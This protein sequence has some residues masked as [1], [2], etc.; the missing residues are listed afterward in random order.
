MIMLADGG[1]RGCFLRSLLLIA[2]A[3]SAGLG[4]VTAVADQ[5]VTLTFSGMYELDQVLDFYNGGASAHGGD[6]TPLGIT[7]SPSAIV[8]SDVSSGGHYITANEPSGPVVM[9][10]N[11]KRSDGTLAIMN[12][13]AGF[14]NAFSLYYSSPYT[15]GSITIHD[16]ANATGNVL[17]TLSLLQTGSDPNSFDPITG[18]HNDFSVWNPVGVQFAG[19]ARSVNFKGAT[20]VSSNVHGAAFDNITLGASTPQL[21]SA[22]NTPAIV[23]TPPAGATTHDSTHTALSN[24]GSIRVFQSQQTDLTGNT[25][26][27]GGQDVYSAGA[28]GKPVL[29]SLDSAGHKL[30]GMA[31]LPAVSSNGNVVA[32]LFTPSAAK[33]AKDVAAGQMWAGA[34]GQPKHQVDKGMGSMPPN[35][36]AS[37]GPSLSS[38]NGTNQLVFC[39]SASNLVPSDGNG[40][41]DIFLIDPLNPAIAAQRVSLDSTG[42]QLPGD[43]C[44]PKLSGD[45]TQV[46]FS[47]SA[48][49]L[50]NTAARQIVRKN[51]TGG[52]KVLVTGQML[53]ITTAPTTGQPANADNSEPTTNQDGSV[54]AFTSQASN[55]DSL[56]TPVGGREV[57]V[58]L[59]P[60]GSSP[61]LIKRL[62]SGDG[63][64]PNGASQHPQI[65]GDGTTVVMQTS[66]T[67]FFQTKSLQAKA[68]G[69]TVTQQCG[70]VAITTNMFNPSALGSNLCS[71]G[72][73]A[74]SNQNPTISGD[75]KKIAVDSD[76]PQPGTSSIN[77][78]PYVQK[79]VSDSSTV[80]GLSG[81]YS[82]QWFD[83]NQSGQ[84]LVIDELNGGF[85]E[86]IWFV[87]TGGQPTWV[88]GAGKLQTGSGAA[89]G[90]VVVQMDQV[91]IYK[92]VSFPLGTAKATPNLWGSITLTFTD[93]NTGTMY[94]TSSYPGFNSGTMQIQHFLPVSLPAADAAGTKIKS[95]HSG[96][97]KEPNKSGHGF[98]FAVLATTPP[99]LAV[100]WFAFTPTGA[101]V[102]L[103]GSA[104][105]SGNSVQVPL[106]L[107]N[108]AGAK[109][110]PNFDSQ[111]VTQNPWG[112]ATFTFTD[113]SHA[114]VAWN[115]T[116]PGYGAGQA[117]LVPTLGPGALARRACQ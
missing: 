93:A 7:F 82:G 26:N 108:G 86:M 90:S 116:I 112:T 94:W 23:F 107:I 105:I 17:A 46:V 103:Y 36:S 62:R 25:A 22:L 45:G 77:N 111:H 61:R 13:P 28:D 4:S 11:A 47:L 53:P 64:V 80:A 3:T 32:F 42:N 8:A 89:A 83:P 84:G 70:A 41:R 60:S 63:K 110:P 57:F 113:I 76:A 37:G 1:L 2:F 21:S 40:A 16:G 34:R 95:C 24:D 96:N 115:S 51:L 92:G 72:G 59:P 54:V 81:D 74:N 102:W 55:L 56:G 109:F 49:S 98:E 12:V 43:S 97:W 50:Y 85:M 91:A 15:S 14:S 106:G 6:G 117:D 18:F 19:T 73:R 27:A 114:H 35:G 79:T 31:S 71:S 67:N 10:F 5:V 69:G 68:V 20:D 66:A 9:A 101:P 104:T 29:E 58:S 100:D 99:I 75:G 38:T 52:S 39:S 88:L 87:Y 65:T 30:I 48:P 78:N 44:E 33:S